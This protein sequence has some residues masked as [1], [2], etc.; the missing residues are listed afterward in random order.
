MHQT[1]IRTNL[2]PKGPQ[3][4]TEERKKHDIKRKTGKKKNF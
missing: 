3:K 1:D 2:S 4:N